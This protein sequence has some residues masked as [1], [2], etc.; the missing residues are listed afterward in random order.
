MFCSWTV[1][2]LKR[3][4]R[5]VTPLFW[6]GF[7]VI[8]SVIFFCRRSKRIAFLKSVNFSTYLYVN[9]QFLWWS[10]DHFLAPFRGLYLPNA[11]SLTLQASKRHTFRVSAF[12]R[13]PLAWG[14]TVSCR[15]CTGQSKGTTK[16]RKNVVF[17]DLALPM[18]QNSGIFHDSSRPHL[19]FDSLPP[20]YRY[21][22]VISI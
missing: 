9:F 13:Y 16:T 18:L 15:L 14:K 17:L 8:S 5:L 4:M 11:W 7:S 12:H 22:S 10:R 3:H 20:K 19:P 6:N 1:A 21:R 2:S